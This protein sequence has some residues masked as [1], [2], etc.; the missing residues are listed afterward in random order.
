MRK[1]TDSMT[2]E[3]SGAHFHLILALYAA[4]L[5]C[6]ILIDSPLEP[7]TPIYAL[8]FISLLLI[9]TIYTIHV[10]EFQFVGGFF[11]LFSIY[12]IYLVLNVLSGSDIGAI[13]YLIVTPFVFLSFII[14][15]PEILENNKDILPI[16]LS[17]LGVFLSSIG[18]FILF[19]KTSMN[20]NLQYFGHTGREVIFIGDFRISS[21][22]ANANAFG[23]FLCISALSSLYLLMKR[24]PYAKLFLVVNVLVLSLTNSQSSYLGFI[25]GSVFIL[26]YNHTRYLTVPVVGASTAGMVVVISGL[27]DNT[28]IS[29]LLSGR[30]Y[31]WRAELKRFVRSPVFGINYENVGEE[32]A[33][34]I[35]E[36][37]AKYRGK[38]GHNS[39]ISIVTRYGLFGGIAYISSLLYLFLKGGKRDRVVWNGYVLGSLCAILIISLFGTL[40]FGGL[41]LTSILLAT[42]VG[43]VHQFFFTST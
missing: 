12:Y 10:R 35:P 8:S 36:E 7:N 30:N 21:I 16:L 18:I 41:S 37:G 39:Y 34:Y 32:I 2:E 13:Q 6:A 25:A 43:L 19:I 23:Q 26:G 28:F 1:N 9:S 15:L 31:L 29:E 17:L 33:P 5:I 42:F 3:I 38:G 27:I 11:L 4:V 22:F 24:K 20:V 14:I 40:T